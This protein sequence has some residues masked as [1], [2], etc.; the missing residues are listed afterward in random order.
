MINDGITEY[1]EPV[2]LPATFDAPGIHTRAAQFGITQLLHWHIAAS[3]RLGSKLYNFDYRDPS[4]PAGSVHAG[5]PLEA[6][7]IVTNAGK[8]RAMKS[9]SFDLKFPDTKGAP[10]IALRGFQRIHLDPGT[11]QKVLFNPTP[12]DLGM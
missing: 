2:G 3:L 9:C 12:R 1:P 10:P 4:L 7:V 5:L 8:L 6:D 11:S